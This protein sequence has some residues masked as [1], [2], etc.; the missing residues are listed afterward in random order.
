MARSKKSTKP[1]AKARLKDAL[2]EQYFILVTGVP[3][4]NVKELLSAFDNMND[5]VFN[6]HVNDS[7]NDFSAWIKDCLGD[8]ELAEE[9]AAIKD[10]HEMQV[11]M[12]KHLVH[13]HL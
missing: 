6:H 13:K 12:L 10:M 11:R 2:P 1:V 3:L 5:W 9:I 7:R 8:K 4:K